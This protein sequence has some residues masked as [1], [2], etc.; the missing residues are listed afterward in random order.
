MCEHPLQLFGR[1]AGVSPGRGG[2]DDAVESLDAPESFEG[3]DWRAAAFDAGVD[4]DACSQSGVL[5]RFEQWNRHFALLAHRHLERELER[6]QDQVGGHERR[7]FGAGDA[8]GGV[9]DG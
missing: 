6:D 5:D 3:V 1:E 7:V 4:R 8:D 2:D 9:E